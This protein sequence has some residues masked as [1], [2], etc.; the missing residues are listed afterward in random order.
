M[1]AKS[2]D[3]LYNRDLSVNF[4]VCVCVLVALLYFAIVQLF[5]RFGVESPCY[6]VL[7]LC[8]MVVCRTLVKFWKA[9]FPQCSLNVR[10]Y[11]IHYR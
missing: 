6:C 3:L 10:T 5:G 11:M 8:A 1:Q 9:E 7:V 4:D 2:M